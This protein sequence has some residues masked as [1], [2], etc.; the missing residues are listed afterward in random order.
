MTDVEAM[1]LSGGYCPARSWASPAFW[2]AE[3]CGAGGGHLI[4]L[5]F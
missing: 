5:Y 1:L 4:P 3:W 2:E